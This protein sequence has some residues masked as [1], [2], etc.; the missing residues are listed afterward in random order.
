MT[1]CSWLDLD[2]RSYFL[3]QIK[4]T[5]KPR[6]FGC[7][8]GRLPLGVA[9]WAIRICAEMQQSNDSLVDIKERLISLENTL[10]DPFSDLNIERVLDVFV[11]SVLDSRPISKESAQILTFSER[12]I[13]S[14]IILFLAVLIHTTALLILFR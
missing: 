8:K 11:S 13:I 2:R 5:R 1:N 4:R 14:F 7:T 12:Y 6:N 9:V 3:P 10:A